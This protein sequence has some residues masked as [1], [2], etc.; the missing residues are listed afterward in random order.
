M[1]EKGRQEVINALIRQEPFAKYIDAKIEIIRPGYSRVS[2]LVTEEMT[3][4]QG[5]THGGLIFT[6]GDIAFGAASNSHG[7]SAVAMNVD[8]CFLRASK[9]GDMLVAEAKEQ[10][11]G[12]RTALYEI[13]VTNQKTGELLAKSQDL[14]YKKREW[15]VPPE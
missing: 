5:F 2:V 9:P 10:Y 4:F 1:E 8:I 14:V 7:Q 3:N 6:L 11:M 12:G 15:F 13:T